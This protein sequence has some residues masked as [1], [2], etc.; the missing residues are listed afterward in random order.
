MEKS[1][2]GSL[3]VFQGKNWWVHETKFEWAVIIPEEDWDLFDQV[4]RLDRAIKVL[5]DRLIKVE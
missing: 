5:K 1:L 2:E 3:V 4:W